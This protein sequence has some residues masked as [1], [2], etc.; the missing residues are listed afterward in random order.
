MSNGSIATLNL[1]FEISLYSLTAPPRVVRA[2]PA[3]CGL[4]FFK[5]VKKEK[6]IEIGK[7][8]PTST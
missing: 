1:G 7:I 4:G 3:L 6:N 8:K 5:T 2:G